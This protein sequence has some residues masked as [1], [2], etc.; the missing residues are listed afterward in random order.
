MKISRSPETLVSYARAFPRFAY[1]TFT[2]YALVN[3]STEPEYA[4]FRG[5]KRNQLGRING[6][7]PENEHVGKMDLSPRD[8]NYEPVAW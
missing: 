7:T 5:D 3:T 2:V 4:P 8:F 1:F 6:Q